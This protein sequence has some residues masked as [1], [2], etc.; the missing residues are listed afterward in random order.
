MYDGKGYPSCDRGDEII[1]EEIEYLTKSLHRLTP[2]WTRPSGIVGSLSSLQGPESPLCLILQVLI[3]MLK[4]WKAKEHFVAIRGCEVVSRCFVVP[5]SMTS[6]AE[7]VRYGLCDDEMCVQEAINIFIV[8]SDSAVSTEFQISVAESGILDAL[9]TFLMDALKTFLMDASKSALQRDSLKLVA[10]V[11]R[12]PKN[13]DKLFAK[14][15]LQ[16]IL[17]LISC[18]QDPKIQRNAIEA[19]GYWLPCSEE[20]TRSLILTNGLQSLLDVLTQ[21]SDRY[22]FAF[23]FPSSLSS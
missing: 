6:D 15:I 9:K 14:G 21:S 13:R 11:A 23:R 8:L 1:H 18:N 4:D 10:C 22:A 20:K 3:Q 17:S 16:D 7:K 2:S 12:N 19:L 5:F